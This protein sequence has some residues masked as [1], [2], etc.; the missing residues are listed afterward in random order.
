M[1]YSILQYFTSSRNPKLTM[2]LV[3]MSDSTMFLQSF[4]FSNGLKYPLRIAWPPFPNSVTCPRLEID[5]TQEVLQN[6]NSNSKPLEVL[7]R[8]NSMTNLRVLIWNPQTLIK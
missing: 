1:S 4:S 2:L 7:E 8:T 6:L 3:L 5:I